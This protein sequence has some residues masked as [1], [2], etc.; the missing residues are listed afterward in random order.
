MKGKE[1]VKLLQRNDWEIDRIHGNHYIMKKSNETETIPVH[2]TG[3]PKGLLN[4][5]MKRRG[6][7]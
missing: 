2:N 7:K 4:A 1:L 3:I 5:I 6:L